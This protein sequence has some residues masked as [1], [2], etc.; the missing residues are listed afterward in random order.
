MVNEST[1]RPTHLSATQEMHVD[2]EDRLPGIGPGVDDHPVSGF[3]D[4]FLTGQLLR[5]E[6]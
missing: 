2:M 3:I 5:R 4:P 1:R 6:E